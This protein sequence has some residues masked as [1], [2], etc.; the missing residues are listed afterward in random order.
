MAP[1]LW[2]AFLF[3][4]IVVGLVVFSGGGDRQVTSPSST[5]MDLDRRLAR[6]I[7]SDLQPFP[8]SMT[9]AELCQDQKAV[10]ETRLRALAHLIGSPD[11]QALSL[12]HLAA[13]YEENTGVQVELLPG[14]TGYVLASWYPLS[15]FPPSNALPGTVHYV[16]SRSGETWD[17]GWRLVEITWVGDRWVARYDPND[18][19]YGAAWR[20]HVVHIERQAGEWV[21]KSYLGYPPE[22]APSHS[23][24]STLHVENVMMDRWQIVLEFSR[25]NAAAPCNFVDGIEFYSSIEHVKL[26]YRWDGAVYTPVGDEVILDTSVYIIRSDDGTY[27]ALLDWPGYCQPKPS[28]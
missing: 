27:E 23:F 3:A 16:I 26:I 21:R 7:Q 19:S 20:S 12:E 24:R 4:G 22:S 1:K 2:V 9:R 13:F 17:V 25:Y 15:C 5:P 10:R 18:L 8:A 14:G 11:A 6:Q 28:H